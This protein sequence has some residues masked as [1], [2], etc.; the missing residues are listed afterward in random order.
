MPYNK[1]TFLLMWQVNAGMVVAES[2]K[3][4]KYKA[5]TREVSRKAQNHTELERAEDDQFS[6][7]FCS[8]PLYKQEVSLY[9]TMYLQGSLIAV[10]K[11]GELH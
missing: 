9:T 10:K 5:K 11:V 6:M 1:A 4:C 7:G 2:Q 8:Y 3:W